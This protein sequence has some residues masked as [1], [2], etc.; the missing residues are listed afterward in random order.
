MVTR[1]SPQKIGGSAS[2]TDDLDGTIS[3]PT[4]ALT[5]N[6]TDYARSLRIGSMEGGSVFPTLNITNFGFS[7]PI[8]AVILGYQIDVRLR[9]WSSAGSSSPVL[10]SVGIIAD[11]AVRAASGQTL[12]SSTTFITQTFGGETSLP[13]ALTADSAN[14]S[15]F[16]VSMRLRSANTGT[17]VYGIDVA[18][19]KITIY[20]AQPSAGYQIVSQ[21]RMAGAGS[22]VTGKTG[23][24]N[25]AWSNPGNITANDNS[26][27]TVTLSSKNNESQALKGSNF[28]FSIPTGLEVCGAALRVGVFANNSN[29]SIFDYYLNDGTSNSST[30]LP[31]TTSIPTTETVREAGGQFNT[32]GLTLTPAIVNSSN[33]SGLLIV[34]TTSS[35]RT[36]SVDYMEMEV[37]YEEPAV[38]SV[39]DEIEAEGDSIVISG[40]SADFRYGSKVSADKGAFSVSGKAAGFGHGQTVVLAKG[41]FTV[42]GKAAT[43]GFGQKVALD[44]GAFTVSGKAATFTHGQTAPLDKG[45]F[46]VSGKQ[47]TLRYGQKVEADKGAVTIS[48]KTAEF[49]SGSKIVADRGSYT[50]SGKAATFSHGQ[51]VELANGSVTIA[52]QTA[53]FTFTASLPL[54]VGHIAVTGW[55]AD[56]RVATSVELAKG[57]VTIS[58]KAA[59]FLTGV[60]VELAAGSVAITGQDITLTHHATLAADKGAVVVTGWDA[61]FILSGKSTIALEAGHFVITGHDP[62]FTHDAK[63]D[64]AVGH[65][66]VTGQSAVFRS[67]EMVP[68]A[69]GH[70]TVTGQDATLRSGFGLLLGAGS[71]AVNGHVAAFVSGYRVA[72]SGDSYLITGYELD[73][74]EDTHL[75]AETGHVV[76]KGYPAVLLLNGKGPTAGSRR[77]R[78]PISLDM[79]V[80]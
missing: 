10:D 22:N 67:V 63:A 11:G 13:Y 4:N 54:D 17:T 36:I 76:I 30:V 66:S 7:V 46:T 61:T 57:S 80:A 28:G 25:T 50:V 19:A 47:A 79:G 32:W 68:L 31:S 14:S 27:A 73:F 15:A 48:G 2:V 18:W 44:K 24:N 64:L 71:Y 69:S 42:A 1:A 75:H 35:S 70:V 53:T 65:I 37:W 6:E 39:H 16:G 49:L 62:V 59:D 8:D 3:N 52:G 60:S 77:R 45:A 20:Y 12:I 43:F 41:A 78:I 33:F 38:T 72:L 29:T 5:D 74:Q 21:T 40:K 58:G 26:Y 23:D 56:L 51:N 9:K 34:T 55:E